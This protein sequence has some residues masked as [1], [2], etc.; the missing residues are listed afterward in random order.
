MSERRAEIIRQ[1]R[2][3][4]D[5][6]YIQIRGIDD[7]LVALGAMNNKDQN[8][9][10]RTDERM[11]LQGRIKLLM[12]EQDKAWNA[13]AVVEALQAEG[14]VGLNHEDPIPGVRTSFVRLRDKGYID[15]V[16]KG[17]YKAKKWIAPG[18]GEVW[19][20]EERDDHPM[21]EDEVRAMVAEDE[22]TARE[23]AHRHFDPAEEPF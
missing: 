2:A 11:T 15:N 21:T 1:L 23:F 20:W 22:A 14:F 19:P 10:P 9:A 7:A 12:E 8:T 6:L 4:R 18:P 5:D 13:A 3:E 17:F 16:S